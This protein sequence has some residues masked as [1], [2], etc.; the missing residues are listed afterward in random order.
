MSEGTNDQ[1]QPI[2]KTK[3]KNQM[4][5]LQ[6]LGETLVKLSAVQLAKIPLQPELAEAI[7]TARTLS[8]RGA[9]RRQLQYIGKL[10]RQIDPIPVQQA[11]S[12]IFNSSSP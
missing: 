7:A 12:Q 5:A 6:K 8:S 2:S 10:M 9:K 3:R 1:T 11:L 4:L